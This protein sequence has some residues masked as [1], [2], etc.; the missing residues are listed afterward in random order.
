MAWSYEKA[1]KLQKD[2]KNMHYISSP[3]TEIM[4]NR[5]LFTEN[6]DICPS[7]WWVHEKS[8]NFRFMNEL[9]FWVTSFQ[10][11]MW[12]RL[13]MQSE[14]LLL[15][16]TMI[17]WQKTSVVHYCSKVWVSMI[18]FKRLILLFSRDILNSSKVAARTII[19][20]HKI[21][22]SNAILLN[23]LFIK[24]SCKKRS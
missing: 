8:S 24:E 6:L 5:L 10:W 13:Q 15:S 18:F 23:L 1:P 19:M 20:F 12:S 7:S 21:S 14:W 22:M 2:Q 9:F 16:E 11:I 3:P 4:W 17:C